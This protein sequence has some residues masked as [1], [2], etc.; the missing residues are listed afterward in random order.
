[1][2]VIGFYLAIALAIPVSGQTG[3][4]IQSNM[5]EYL[6]K[7][8]REKLFL[9]LA[10]PRYLTGETI[11]F[12]IFHY[13]E[14]DHMP[15]AFS[16]VVYVD[17]INKENEIVSKQKIRI[18]EKGGEG[19]MFLPTDL[20]S[21]Q[22]QIRAYTLWMRNF[23]ESFFFT[24][25]IEII[26]P[27]KR[28]NLSEEEKDKINVE[29]FPEGGNLVTGKVNVAFKAVDKHGNGLDFNGFLLDRDNDTIMNFKPN[30][31]GMGSFKMDVSDGDEIRAFSLYDGQISQHQFPLP[32]NSGYGLIATS[33]NG[34]IKAWVRSPNGAKSV[35]LA[36]ISRDKFI[37]IKSGTTSDSEPTFEFSEKELNEGINQLTIF[38]E[39]GIPVCE[40]LIFRYPGEKLS[41]DINIDTPIKSN[42]ERVAINLQALIGE[43]GISTDLS[44][45]VFKSDRSDGGQDFESSMWLSNELKGYIQSP[46][47]YFKNP[48]EETHQDLDYL[49][50]TQGWRVY[51]SNFNEPEHIY[52]PEF[53]DQTLQG[54]IINT[55]TSEPIAGENVFF[56]FPNKYAQLFVTK[57]DSNGKIL[58][59][60]K[61]L[62]GISD[63]YLRTKLMDSLQVDIQLEDPFQD[64][65]IEVLP[66][67]DPDPNDS[68]D[69]IN[70]SANMQVEN[71]F[72]LRKNYEVA[73]TS[74]FYQKPGSTYY[75]D[76]YTRFPVMEE[77]MREYVYGVFVRKEKGK[78]VFKVI[79]VP[80]NKLM[81][82]SPLVLLDGVP[83]FDIDVIMSIDPLH[84]ERI[85]VIRNKYYYG[86]VNLH[87]IVAFYSYNTDLPQFPLSEKTIKYNYQG[88]Q[89]NKRFYSPDYT[90][91]DNQLGRY[92]DFRN[93]LFWNPGISTD[94]NGMAF[95]HFFTSDAEGMY[96]IQVHGLSQNGLPGSAQKSF[97]VKKIKKDD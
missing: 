23:D 9:H 6:A 60:T 28:L 83:V 68:P 95:F 33:Q 69:L 96:T 76:D 71:I 62:Y 72:T 73:D 88:F 42:R 44:V 3:K 26:N 75:L 92:P 52:L 37:F 59:E 7:S 54:T 38:D 47:Y 13:S 18:N 78:F 74:S 5:E 12:R 11:W 49:M 93:Q 51:D 15:F 46:S 24:Q 16:K 14:R 35:Y 4:S 86:H 90:T 40:R 48:S 21:G 8:P 70:E 43:K 1:L 85:E 65:D 84:I 32:Q 58:F 27:F 66:A 31:F 29:F 79:D 55:Q 25:S 34:V 63:V 82:E 39:S 80:R 17:L 30:R 22:Y 87:G 57:S 97:E 94:E 10:K 81:E 61:D 64:P 67:F 89:K 19:R 45:S 20:N 50:L 53:I 56:S 2:K 41:I 91:S 36:V 77:V